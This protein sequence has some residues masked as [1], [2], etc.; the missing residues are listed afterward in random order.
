MQPVVDTLR[1]IRF[2]NC[3]LTSVGVWVGAYLTW[4]TPV[5]YGPLMASV[6]AFLVCAAGN[7]INDVLD[8][9]IDRVNRP[10]RVLPQGRLSVR[11][12][13]S[14]AA[15]CG[16]VALIVAWS[17]NWPV[18]ITVVAALILLLAY[19]FRLK[20]IPLLGNFVVAVLGGLTFVTGGLAVKMA[21]TWQL[22]G[23]LIPAIFALLFHL[24]REILKDVEDLEGDR[25]AGI[26]TLPQVV[27]PR[28][29]L[30][31]ALGLFVVLTVLTLVPVLAGWFG[32]VYKVITV[33]IIDLPLL[34]LLI[35]IWG[36]PSPRMLAVGSLGLKIG[37]ALG[38]VALVLA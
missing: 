1:L 36:N 15:L 14:L 10:R 21:W 28:P 3:L 11:F 27:G 13:V 5:Y 25:Q 34:V 29:A 17:V 38:V 26:R 22:P 24:V 35:V 32:L 19:N 23:P 33:Y 8:I 4:G 16:G 6:A 31:V 9:E 18:T 37:M 30:G 12:A 7:C 2:F 20:H